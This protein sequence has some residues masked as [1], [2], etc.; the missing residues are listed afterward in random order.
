MRYLVLALGLLATATPARADDGYC[1]Y[2]RGVAAAESALMFAP[3]VFT[4]FGRIE[5]AS[6]SIQEV[7]DPGTLR[8]IGGL[9]W[10]IS[11]LYEGAA[12][13]A[14]ASAECRRHN[15]LAGIRGAT[16]Y[17]ALAARAAV[18]D[19]ALPAAEKLLARI[20]ADLDA[21]R[22]TAQEATAARLRVE[23]LRRLADETHQAMSVLPPPPPDGQL[24]LVAFQRADADVERHEAT[25]RRARA[26]DLSVRVG[27]DEF[28][29]DSGTNTSSPY[30]AVVT[31]NINLG[32]LF[33][34]RG[35]ARAA[36]GRARYLK[37]GRDPVTVDATADRLRA[38]LETATR[39]ADETAALEADLQR[40]LK[41]LDRVGGDDSRRYRQIV[42]FD[43][44]K[45][46]AEHAYHDAHATALR[47]VVG[48]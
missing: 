48:G 24:G 5:Q 6:T 21:R 45:V 3:E 43:L 9:R 41:V 13:R 12:T 34:G 35:N 42:W 23:E 47:Q 44:I 29:D 17:K 2:V 36:A 1:D 15:A 7:V 33:Q 20:T 25:I 37:S 14:R 11:G 38:Q 4:E 39:R 22:T 16:L 46:R 10:R 31:A 27:V 18:L 32:L 8:F 30:F 28:L 26:V 40:Q 19:G